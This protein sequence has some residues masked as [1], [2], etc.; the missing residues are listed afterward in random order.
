MKNFRF[1]IVV[2]NKANEGLVTEHGYALYVENVAGNLLLDTGQNS[3]LLPNAK[4][5]GVDLKAGLGLH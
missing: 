1:T 2:D 5:L 4:T 3:A